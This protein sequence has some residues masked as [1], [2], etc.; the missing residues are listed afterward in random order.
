MFD[1]GRAADLHKKE[2]S[3]LS[4]EDAPN[5]V[6]QSRLTRNRLGFTPLFTFERKSFTL[7]ETGFGFYT[8]MN[9]FRKKI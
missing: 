9:L 8:S 6:G 4:G 2:A 7:L 3:S 5:P 1:A